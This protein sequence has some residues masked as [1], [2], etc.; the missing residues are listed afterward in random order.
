[1]YKKN[2]FQHYLAFI[3]LL[4]MELNY[5]LWYSHMI[6][7]GMTHMPDDNIYEKFQFDSLVLG[8]LKLTQNIGSALTFF[9]ASDVQK[10]TL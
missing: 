3:A 8:S 7:H 1:M 5:G 6:R 2:M 9:P 4:L 10:I